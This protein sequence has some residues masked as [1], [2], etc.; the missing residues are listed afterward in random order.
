MTG[1]SEE[2]KIKLRSVLVANEEIVRTGISAQELLRMSVSYIQSAPLQSVEYNHGHQIALL[3]HTFS[4]Y[5]PQYSI[6]AQW[7]VQFE[8]FLEGIK[9]LVSWYYSN[10]AFFSFF[11]PYVRYEYLDVGT[12]LTYGVGCSLLVLSNATYLHWD[13]LKVSHCSLF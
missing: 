13:Q 12:C 10:A 2:H 9:Q 7:C 8:I 6:V 11:L 1:V 5:K 4:K 3:D